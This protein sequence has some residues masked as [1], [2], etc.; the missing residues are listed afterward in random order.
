[1]NTKDSVSVDFSVILL[2]IITFVESWESFVGMRD[3]ESTVTG[4]LQG[5]KNSVSD[6]G[7]SETHVE[8]SEEWSSFFV[9][10]F[11]NIINRAVDFGV[12]GVE[13]V[14]AKLL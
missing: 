4:S 1:M 2:L 3:V 11:T 7:S 12:S 6:G 9:G 10:F 8:V 14:H 5:T 13:F